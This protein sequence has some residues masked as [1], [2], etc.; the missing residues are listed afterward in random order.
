MTVKEIQ[1]AIAN[2][3]NPT[4]AEHSK[5]FF[6]TG[7]GEYAEGDIFTGANV[8]SCRRIA[9][10]NRELS[11]TDIKTLLRSRIHEERMVALLILIDQFNNSSATSKQQL[12]R[13]YLLNLKFV[14]NW[15]LVDLSAPVL[16]GIPMLTGKRSAL[17][18]LA[19]SK[20]L[21]TRRVSI[22][23]TM[24]L[25]RNDQLQDT[26]R[27][28]RLLMNDSHDLI[29]KACGWMLREAGKRDEKALRRFLDAN[30]PRMP[31]TMLRY[32]IER[33]PVGVRTRYLAR[34][35]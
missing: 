35:S 32:A 10:V 14:N 23:S 31:R 18:K 26:F 12:M 27:I 33:L 4:R 3:G 8:P 24:T 13:L 17:D 20:H 34:S 7:K 2:A 22:V 15:D 19:R 1:K 28:T 30:G 25:I 5:R 21:W 9:R 16:V 29:H 6:K 11:L